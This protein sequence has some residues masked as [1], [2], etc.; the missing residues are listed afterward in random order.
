MAEPG[1]WDVV[2]TVKATQAQIESFWRHHLALGAA[3]VFLFMDD[4]ANT[5]IASDPRVCCIRADGSDGTQP[6]PPAIEDRQTDNATRAARISQSDWILHCDIDEYLDADG[7][8][9]RVLMRAGE[10]VGVLLVPPTEPVYTAFP[11]SF[12]EILAAAHFKVKTP[13]MEAASAFWA[14]RY[15]EMIGLTNAGFWGHRRGKSLYRT[16]IAREGRSIPL[17]AFS[18]DRAR[19]LGQKEA[20]GL[21]LRHFDALDFDSWLQKNCARVQGGVLARMAGDKRNALSQRIHDALERGGP[22]AARALFTTMFGMDET[23][24]AEG[25][26]QGFITTRKPLRPSAA[27]AAEPEQME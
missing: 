10:E 27:V 5:Y 4:P 14:R 16:R 22:D 17:H 9:S 20:R 11:T 12:A 23:L 13:D 1:S 24:L 2:T 19:K 3:R 26:A 25:L 15:G 7:R 21:H 18:H 6:R 8:V